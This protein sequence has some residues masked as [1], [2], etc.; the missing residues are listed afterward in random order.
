LNDKRQYPNEKK[1]ERVG[2]RI[3]TSAN[4][5]ILKFDQNFKHFGEENTKYR[6]YN[7]IYY[8]YEYSKG[9]EQFPVAAIGEQAAK[10]ILFVFI[11]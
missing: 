3:L 4:W 10:C 7:S 8:T 2:I 5:I 6:E 9:K 11:D 1:H